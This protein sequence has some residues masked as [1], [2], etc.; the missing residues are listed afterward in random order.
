LFPTEEVKRSKRISEVINI[1]PP[2]RRTVKTLDTNKMEIEEG[3]EIKRANIKKGGS[4]CRV[5]EIKK[6]KL[7]KR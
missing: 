6:E 1:V 5:E 2:E 7:E 4:L 3:L